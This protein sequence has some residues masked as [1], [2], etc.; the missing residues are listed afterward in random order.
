MRKLSKFQ[1]K[2]YKKI[3][4]EVNLG[5]EEKLLFKNDYK[6][7]LILLNQNLQ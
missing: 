7:L 4:K 2:E 3:Y 5:E 6:D 1:T